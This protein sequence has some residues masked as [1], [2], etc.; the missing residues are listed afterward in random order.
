MIL[1]VY[2]SKYG[3]TREIAEHIAS[4]LSDLGQDATV[5][6]AAETTDLGNPSS[7]VVGSPDARA[8]ARRRGERRAVCRR[9]VRALHLALDR[10]A[11]PCSSRTSSRDTRSRA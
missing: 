8:A 10:A 1:V 5:R 6:P 7:V 2:A 4:K 11:A 9:R 3:T